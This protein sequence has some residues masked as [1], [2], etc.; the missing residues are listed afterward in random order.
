MD[1]E[2]QGGPH[3]DGFHARVIQD[4]SLIDEHFCFHVREYDKYDESSAKSSATAN[5]KFVV[6]HY[7]SLYEV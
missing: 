1:E 3:E 2:V 7:Y 4:A 5:T 6:G